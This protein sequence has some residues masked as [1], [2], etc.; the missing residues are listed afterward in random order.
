MFFEG[1]VFKGAI[2][3]FFFFFFFWGG[4]GYWIDFQNN[5][6]DLQI[7]E[8]KIRLLSKSSLIEL[9]NTGSL[10]ANLM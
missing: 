5:G 3:F 4:G 9:K 8:K 10:D 6:I 1:Q 7:K 2:H